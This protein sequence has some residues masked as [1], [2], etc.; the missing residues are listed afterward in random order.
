[1]DT[2]PA[3]EGC[4]FY[5]TMT[6]PEIGLVRG[7][8]YIE[9][10]PQYVGGIDLRNKSVL[11]VGTASGFL[12][13]EAE[14]AGALTVTSFDADTTAR[15]Y[16]LPFRENLFWKDWPRWVEE[17]DGSW[18]AGLKAAWRRAH[19][20]LGSKAEAR[21][22]DI[23]QLRQMFPD[24][25]DVTIAGAI[26][27][28]ISDPVSALASI[29]TVTRERLVVAFTPILDSDEILLQ[30]AIPMTDPVS[31]FTWWIG[32]RGMYKRVLE[33]MGFEIESITKS[34]AFFEPDGVWEERSTLI[35]RRR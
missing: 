23:F 20:C 17:N 22:G 9:E 4:Y 28:H 29:A 8:W 15:M 3:L 12:S 14:R 10:F 33:N 13:F 32:S 27:E 5:H 31:D 26:L 25:F 6:L 18:L 1:M 21:Y 30:A 2:M 34:T 11:D 16:R 35:A 7:E 24:G 19:D